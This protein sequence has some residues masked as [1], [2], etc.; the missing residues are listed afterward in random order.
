MEGKKRVGREVEREQRELLN[1]SAKVVDRSDKKAEGMIEGA[2]GKAKD[3]VRE[4]PKKIE[5]EP[6]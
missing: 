2:F 1:D 5:H 4:A 6:G 3:V